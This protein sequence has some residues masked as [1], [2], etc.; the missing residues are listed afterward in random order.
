MPYDAHGMVLWKDSHLLVVNKPTGLLSLPD[1]YDPQKP[2]L[3]SVLEPEFGRLWIV[4]R[5]DR[6][7]SGVLV[8]ARTAEAHRDLN[9]QFEHR[10]TTKVYQALVTGNPPWDELVVKLKLRADGDRRHR[11][12]VDHRRGKEA[13][14]SFRVLRQFVDFALVEAIPKTGR[15]HQ[16][17]AHLAA[18]GFPVVADPLYGK[19]E[20][21][22]Y[23]LIERL[24]LHAFSLTLI[25]PKSGKTH[26]YQA[27]QPQDFQTVLSV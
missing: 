26:H 12:I 21:P 19:C 25:H 7:C 6:E 2:H 20:H 24:G 11:T 3:K 15:P 4:H 1:G 13:V 16:I 23:N 22:A 14:T 5:L 10:Q 8:L 27:L 9:T 18:K 17:R